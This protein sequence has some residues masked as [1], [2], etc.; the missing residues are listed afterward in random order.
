MKKQVLKFESEADYDRFIAQSPD[1]ICEQLMAMEF[2]VDIWAKLLWEEKI[3]KRIQRTTLRIKCKKAVARAIIKE[4]G[5]SLISEYLSGEGNLNQQKR[6]MDS[7]RSCLNAF[8]DTIFD[9]R[10]LGGSFIC[11]VLKMG[12]KDSFSASQYH[13]II[14]HHYPADFKKSVA[15]LW[16]QYE[17]SGISSQFTVEQLEE[18][19]KEKKYLEIGDTKLYDKENVLALLKDEEARGEVT[20]KELMGVFTRFE[21]AAIYALD[22]YQDFGAYWSDYKGA[23]EWLAERQPSV[24]L[25]VMATKDLLNRFEAWRPVHRIRALSVYDQ[26]P[27]VMEADEREKPWYLARLALEGMIGSQDSLIKAAQYY[28]DDNLEWAIYLYAQAAERGSIPALCALAELYRDGVGVDKD[29]EQA[30]QYLTVAVDGDASKVPVDIIQTCI[31]ALLEEVEGLVRLCE[32]S[33][34]RQRDLVA[35]SKI[36]LEEDKKNALGIP[37]LLAKWDGLSLDLYTNTKEAVEQLEAIIDENLPKIKEKL[38]II[39]NFNI[40]RLGKDK[41][42]ELAFYEPY[43]RAHQLLIKLVGE[44]EWLIYEFDNDMF[45][46]CKRRVSEYDEHIKKPNKGLTTVAAGGSGQLFF[47]GPRRE[48]LERG[49]GVKARP[50]RRA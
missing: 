47:G 12:L 10:E 4:H 16:E 33:L 6:P 26:F 2:D 22:H 1:A 41:S 17:V 29:L 35:Q 25:K 5:F 50:Q 39:I 46:R 49:D 8:W 43:V 11:D 15:V 14:T 28:Q 40:E 3:V 37:G 7:M 48:T 42:Q 24:A 13:E 30:M 31:C 44:Y 32:P 21:E 45:S 20:N 38:E 34:K 27:D 19:K 36:Y 18:L 9:A 23:L